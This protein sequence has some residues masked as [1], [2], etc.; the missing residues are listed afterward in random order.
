MGSV[1]KAAVASLPWM[2]CLVVFAA[3]A[4]LIPGYASLGS[5]RSVLLL[6]SLLG[7]AAIGQTLTILLGGFDLSIPAVMGMA[8]VMVALLYGQGWPIAAVLMVV[9]TAATIIG[10]VNGL[11]IRLLRINSLIVTLGTGSIVLGAVL[12]TTRGQ[13]G[14]SVPDWLTNAVSVI[15]TTAGVGLP[16]AVVLWI[17]L[18]LLVV[19]LQYRTVMGRWIF[20]VGANPRAAR[21]ADV[22]VLLVWVAVY[23]VSAVMAAIAGVLLVGL[24]GAADVGVGAPYLF[25]TVAAV[26]VGGTSLLG[27]RGGYERTIPGCF[28]IVMLSTLFAG[29]GLNQSGQQI[30]FGVL[31]VALVALYGR[32]SHVRM[33][34]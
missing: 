23:A 15:G 26:V 2:C 4:Y 24:G 7:I 16:G 1:R 20:A 31:I 30:G 32:E 22:P 34:V 33:R 10:A 9:L 17:V 8:D 6:A 28:L 14:G 13:I 19:A 11:M 5:V 21:L 25:T 12:S 3:T 29:L 27:G 18:S